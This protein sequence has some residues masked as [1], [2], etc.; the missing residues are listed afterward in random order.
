MSTEFEIEFE[1]STFPPVKIPAGE[2]LSE[3]LHACNSMILFGCRS[4]LCGTCL[5]EVV[6]GDL[7]PPSPDEREALDVYAPGNPRARLACQIDI[8]GPL[9][10]KNLE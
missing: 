3:H 10:I 2:N 1:D 4:G 8:F 9:K 7:T 6:D 5:I